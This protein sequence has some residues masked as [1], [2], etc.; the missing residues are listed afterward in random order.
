MEN[1]TLVLVEEIKSFLLFKKKNKIK[2][3]DYSFYI[4]LAIMFI[5]T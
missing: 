5:V 1:K 3:N 4:Q 2:I